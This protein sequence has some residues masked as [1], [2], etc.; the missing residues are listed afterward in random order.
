M[1]AK[2]PQYIDLDEFLEFFSIKGPV[3]N[4]LL[5]INDSNETSEEEEEAH[6]ERTKMLRKIRSL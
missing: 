3:T 1:N 6:D 2:A 4:V 5:E